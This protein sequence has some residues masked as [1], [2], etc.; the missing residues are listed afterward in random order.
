MIDM[1]PQNQ[2]YLY[3]LLG[4]MDT[5]SAFEQSIQ[6]E[7]ERPPLAESSLHTTDLVDNRANF[8]RIASLQNN[9]NAE[10]TA[11]GELLLVSTVSTMRQDDTLSPICVP[12]GDQMRPAR[13]RLLQKEDADG[14]LVHIAYTGEA[15][16]VEL[17]LSDF[18]DPQKL[19][20]LQ[21]PSWVA[22]LFVHRSAGCVLAQV[23]AL[24]AEH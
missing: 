3:A 21:L 23:R 4:T 5:H 9:E 2:H 24:H 13:V 10:S 11:V 20:M 16:P 12:S 17:N 18:L 1:L 6:L 19:N 14:L 15:E 7:S 22:A 8:D